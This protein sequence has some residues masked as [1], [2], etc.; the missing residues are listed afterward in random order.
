MA[1]AEATASDAKDYDYDIVIY[2]GSFPGTAAAIMA[3]SVNPTARILLIN[4][5][6][7]LGSIG[8]VGGQNYMD[9]RNWAADPH[10]AQWGFRSY[11]TM[12]TYDRIF[13]QTGQAYN[14][15]ETAA[16]LQQMV[17]EHPNV[18][19]WHQTDVLA[20][21]TAGGQ[22]SQG[23]EKSQ[24]QAQGQ[25]Q[26]QGQGESKGPGQ[27]DG[28]GMEQT[29]APASTHS[30]VKIVSITVQGVR[31]DPR[32]GY[33]LFDP[34]SPVRRVRGQVFIDAS[35]TGRL[36][37]LSGHFQGTLG[38]EDSG[39]R[40]FMVN[41]LMFL[42]RGV[43]KEKLLSIIRSPNGDWRG[44]LDQDGTLL[45]WGGW[46]ATDPYT[47]APAIMK[48]NESSPRFHLKA[49]NVAQNGTGTDEYW[50]NMLLVF[51]VD[52]RLEEKDRGTDRFPEP[53][54]QDPNVPPWSLDEAWVQARRVLTTPEFLAA[55]RSFPAFERVELVPDKDGLPKVG[56]MMYIREALHSSLDPDVVSPD[57]YALTAE[58]VAL[59]GVG[60]NDGADRGNYA[61]RIGLSFYQQDSNGYIK[62]KQWSGWSP[63]GEPLPLGQEPKNPVY[64][65]YEVMTTPAIANLLVPNGSANA[66][67]WAWSELRV[68]P[69]LTVVGDAAGVAAGLAVKDGWAE[70]VG[71]ATDAQIA[72]VQTALRQLGAR[73]DK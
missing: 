34:S 20:V 9:I 19:V 10:K 38:R 45:F 30:A 57:N 37:R 43:D 21:E 66:S 50:V 48:F 3:A 32:S 15:D 42:V 55:L 11:V 4:P 47:G 39:D 25:A 60:P 31:R 22:Q 62:W 35:D 8:T 59:A 44:T 36:T 65:P 27:G 33:V 13:R 7:G 29:A 12:G 58:E 52:P 68:I 26:G 73:L 24:G 41:T 49:A 28:S 54:N 64:L 69:N 63:V 6:S 61:H 46:A 17:S 40:R 5:Q 23:W 2:G 1:A 51:N 72:S 71:Q 56:E 18:T 53:V 67:R 70:Q 16:L 14:T